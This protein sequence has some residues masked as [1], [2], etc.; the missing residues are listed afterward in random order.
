MRPCPRMPPITQDERERERGRE[1][2]RE[3]EREGVCEVGGGRGEAPPSDPAA[4]EPSVSK[5][6]LGQ[7]VRPWAVLEITRTRTLVV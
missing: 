7:H 3:R 2:E 6:G 4:R 1:R 5:G